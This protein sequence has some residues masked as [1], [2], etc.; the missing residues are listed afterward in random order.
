MPLG[1]A[2]GCCWIMPFIV[3]GAGYDDG[4][5]K[6]GYVPIKTGNSS[7]G[8]LWQHGTEPITYNKIKHLIK[9]TEHLQ[10]K[11]IF[12]TYTTI[13]PNFHNVARCV[14]CRW[15]RWYTKINTVCLIFI[16]FASTNFS[17]SNDDGFIFMFC[18]ICIDVVSDLLQNEK[19]EWKIEIW[20]NQF[21][22]IFFQFTLINCTVNS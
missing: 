13:I 9:L 3:D 8:L 18:T 20:S 4:T 22:T 5:S 6:M 17:F 21:E 10:K 15:N 19:K 1:D 11:Y 2:V 7:V 12:F 16:Y 14:I